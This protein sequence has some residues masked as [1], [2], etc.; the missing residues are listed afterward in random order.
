[1]IENS[2]GLHPVSIASM[3]NETRKSEI[4][5]RLTL[6]RYPRRSKA[7]FTD[8]NDH[9]P[10]VLQ[11]CAQCY[12]TGHVGESWAEHGMRVE[13][14]VLCTVCNGSGVTGEAEP[15][16]AVEWP[17]VEACADVEGWVTCP[18]CGWRFTIGDRRAWSGRRH[19]RCGQKIVVVEG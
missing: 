12:G 8:E 18:N 1:V 13:A 2:E 15:Y 11:D 17:A 14:D 16:F 3:D 5:R 4:R 6:A 9:N 19:L 10:L 7:I